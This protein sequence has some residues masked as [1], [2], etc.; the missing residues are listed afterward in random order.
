MN[1]YEKTTHFLEQLDINALS[2]SAV[3]SAVADFFELVICPHDRQEAENVA[4]RALTEE[5][6]A[7]LQVSI[8]WLSLG[9]SHDAEVSAIAEALDDQG[10]SSSYV[11]PF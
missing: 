3:L 2:Q 6:W 1:T 7:T 5:E 4:G 10:I 8:H 9:W 11:S